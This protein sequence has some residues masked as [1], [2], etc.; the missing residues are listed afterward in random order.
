MLPPFDLS[1]PVAAP[2]VPKI[3]APCTP[4]R[5]K[6]WRQR[7][8]GGIE[9]RMIPVCL[10]QLVPSSVFYMQKSAKQVY[11]TALEYRIITMA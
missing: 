1:P 5:A 11:D 9:I 4:P 6:H 10:Q 7:G 3:A 8:G 2:T